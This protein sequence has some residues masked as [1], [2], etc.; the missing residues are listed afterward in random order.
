M[1]AA[2][3]PR[4]QPDP[5]LLAAFFDG[6]LEG[7]DDLADLRARLEIWLE[8]HPE[9]L[10]EWHE[11]QRLQKLWQDTSPAEPTNSTW[12]ETLQ[13][14]DAERKAP[15]IK[16]KRARPWLTAGIAIACVGLLMVALIGA[17]RYP[18][19][20]GGSDE[21]MVQ[22]PQPKPGPAHAEDEVFAVATASEIVI[23]RV[24]GADTDALVVGRPPVVGP[25]ELA[26]AGDIVI[27]RVRPDARDNMMPFV[28]HKG[29]D[30][31]M[32]S[33]RLD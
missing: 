7:R 19:T 27:V 13:R 16:P 12:N 30:R 3:D 9:A 32:V 14:I 2:P 22:Q 21:P 15:S 6:E 26:D 17:L 25:L 18:W 20:S 10:A 1:N 4:W 28:R 5:Q 24:E 23:L 11:H 31:P 33:A 8:T 29:P